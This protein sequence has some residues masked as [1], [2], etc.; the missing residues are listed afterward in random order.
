M[1]GFGKG[2]RTLDATDIG[3]VGFHLSEKLLCRVHAALKPLK[4]L[5]K[6]R[7]RLS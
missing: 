5:E 3:I 7:I 2:N 1:H 6:P 4:N